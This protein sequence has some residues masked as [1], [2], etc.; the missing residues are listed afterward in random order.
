MDAYAKVLLW[1]RC[2]PW[3]SSLAPRPRLPRTSVRTTT[4]ESTRPTA[5]RALYG[6]MASL[7]LRQIVLTT[8]YKPS[9]PLTIQDKGHLDRT[10]PAAVAAGLRV[11]LDVYPYPPREV[12]A[13][14]ASPAAFG[15]YVAAVATAF[16]ER[17]AVRHRQRAQPA[18]VL[19][20]SVRS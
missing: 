7:G 17:Q 1:Q 12:E 8:R 20:A 13:G 2:S 4:R 9:D 11:V 19:A 16:P 5:E 6:D 18:R 15:A 14:L 3:R 10:I